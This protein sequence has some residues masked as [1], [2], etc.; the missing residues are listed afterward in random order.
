MGIA[1]ISD[2]S[3]FYSQWR[4]YCSISWIING[5]FINFWYYR[6]PIIALIA[7]YFGKFSFIFNSNLH[8]TFLEPTTWKIMLDERK[9]YILQLEYFSKKRK[10]RIFIFKN[11][12]ILCSTNRISE[13][14]SPLNIRDN[15]EEGTERESFEVSIFFLF[16]FPPWQT[17]GRR[18]IFLSPDSVSLQPYKSSTK[19]FLQI[20]SF[21]RKFRGSKEGSFFWKRDIVSRRVFLRGLGYTF[22]FG[23]ALSRPDRFTA[24]CVLETI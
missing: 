15:S 9:K 8:S 18:S 4:R 6:Y 13:N 10:I 14:I 5:C 20:F 22:P 7:A 11:L 12:E 24:R 2:S 19:Q 23:H 16:L 17:I 21:L 1:F 3:V